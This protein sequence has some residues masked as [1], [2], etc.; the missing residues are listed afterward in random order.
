MAFLYRTTGTVSQLGALGSETE[1]QRQWDNAQRAWDAEQEEMAEQAA[2]RRIQF[3]LAPDAETFT[4]ALGFRT[5]PDDA[6]IAQF[7]FEQAAAGNATAQ[8]F[9]NAAAEVYAEHGDE[10]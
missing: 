6:A 10:L 7:I 9:I 1:A 4:W 5:G 2:A 8:G 3:L